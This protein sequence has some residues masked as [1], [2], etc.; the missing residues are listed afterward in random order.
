MSEVSRL[1]EQL[2]IVEDDFDAYRRNLNG[3][4][5]S[6]V[7]N[8]YLAVECGDMSINSGYQ[9][10]HALY[11]V[12]NGYDKDNFLLSVLESYQ[13]MMIGEATDFKKVGPY[14]VSYTPS[15]RRIVIT[16]FVKEIPVGSPESAVARFRHVLKKLGDKYDR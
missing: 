12:F 4:I 15:Q 5:T 1:K 2:K 10:L 8:V 13:E 14:H 3:K 7:E 16:E 11:S 6:H 9:A